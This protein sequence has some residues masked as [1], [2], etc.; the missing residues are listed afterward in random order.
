VTVAVTGSLKVAERV[1]AR[2]AP[3][4]VDLV[5]PRGNPME[6]VDESREPSTTEE[7][8]RHLHEDD[9]RRDDEP[10]R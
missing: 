2:N 4:R 3:L 6:V 7:L 1:M 5:D 10:P 9:Y 8:R